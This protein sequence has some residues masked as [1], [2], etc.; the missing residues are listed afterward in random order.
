MNNSFLIEKTFANKYYVFLK[1]TQIRYLAIRLCH[2]STMLVY[3]LKYFANKSNLINGT[4][5]R[6]T[7]YE[8]RISKFDSTILEQ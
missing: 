5:I 6:I 4:S 2:E 1:L 3:F 7:Y 8:S